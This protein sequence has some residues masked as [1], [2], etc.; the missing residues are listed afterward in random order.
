MSQF[1]DQNLDLDDYSVNVVK[2]YEDKQM[3]QVKYT[4]S[5]PNIWLLLTLFVIA[6]VLITGNLQAMGF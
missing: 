5:K 4:S 2:H 3:N 6:G 1:S